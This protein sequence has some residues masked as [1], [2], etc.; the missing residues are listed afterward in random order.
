MAICCAWR[1]V[2]FFI[3]HDFSDYQQALIVQSSKEGPPEFDNF[4]DYYASIGYQH[5]G[6]KTER[7]GEL[8]AG[9][10][11]LMT[12]A[13][14]E[15][16]LKQGENALNIVAVWNDQQHFERYI[17]ERRDQG[18]INNDDT[19]ILIIELTDDGK[20]GFTYEK[21]NVSNIKDLIATQEKE[22]AEEMAN[23]PITDM[24]ES[25]MVSTKKKEPGSAGPLNTDFE[26]PEI[27][28][29]EIETKK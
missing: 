18:E 6:N 23:K 28:T 27:E 29:P 25:E 22:Q 11:Y 4:P 7:E 15:W 13:L 21:P 5:K 12:D 1:F 8:T 17:N 2:P 10:F 14:A 26:S 16:F 24:P 19:T 9:T 20:V 3:P